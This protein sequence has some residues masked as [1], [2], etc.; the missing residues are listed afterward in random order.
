MG[1]ITPGEAPSA[2]FTTA[3]DYNASAQLIYLGKAA[4]GSA[5]ASALWKIANLLYDASGNLIDIQF[6]GGD[7][8]Y[9]HVWNDR[10]TLVYS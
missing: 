3:L 8:L 1:Q 6:A 7:T 4:S 10:A 2:G 5:K 9:A